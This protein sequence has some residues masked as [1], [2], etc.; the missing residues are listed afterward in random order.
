MCLFGDIYTELRPCRRLTGV[1]IAFAMLLMSKV[2]GILGASLVLFV[3]NLMTFLLQW[4]VRSRHSGKE[5]LVKY[6]RLNIFTSHTPHCKL[7]P[8][9]QIPPLH[10]PHL[11]SS[12]FPVTF[13]QPSRSV[14]TKLS[15][16][17]HVAGKCEQEP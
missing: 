15:I 14:V 8:I 1:G 3:R 12:D 11:K 16:L 4:T 5:H 7:S 6:Y 9:H 2:Y 13:M 10:L 17:L